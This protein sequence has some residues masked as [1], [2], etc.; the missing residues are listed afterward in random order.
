[1]KDVYTYF[2][3]IY[4]GLRYF[5]PTTHSLFYAIISYFIRSLC[6]INFG[7]IISVIARLAALLLALIIGVA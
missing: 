6:L 3:K 1:M 7:I 4:Q 2:G 5:S